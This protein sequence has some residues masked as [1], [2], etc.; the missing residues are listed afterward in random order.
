VQ[1]L[2]E[3][4]AALPNTQVTAEISGFGN[5]GTDRMREQFYILQVREK[6]AQAKFTDAR[7]VL[8]A[9]ERG[10]KQ[11]TK[12]PARLYQQAE[13]ALL[14]E[15][16]ALASLQAQAERLRVQ[17]AGVRQELTALNEHEMRI[18]ALQREVD[19]LETDYRKYSASMEQARID[20]QL[21]AQHMSNI[22]VV[23]PAS[24]E[25][26]PLRPQMMMNL[27]LGIGAGLFGGLALPF[28]LEQFGGLPAAPADRQG[29]SGAAMPAATPRRSRQLVGNGSGKG[30]GNGDGA[31]LTRE[32]ETCS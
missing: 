15:E 21:E 12:E 19:L 2:R 6:E 23:Q 24:F 32:K 11:V 31:A 3:K 30:V 28:V 16:P 10:R 4:L 22:G 29:E 26:R 7:A 25:R 13:S 5:D 9:E 8:D 27:L 14:S 18:A 17:L 1:K 20:Q